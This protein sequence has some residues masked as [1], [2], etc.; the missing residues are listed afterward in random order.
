MHHLDAARMAVDHSVGRLDMGR[1]LA[2][3]AV[4][5]LAQM[6]RKLRLLLPAQMARPAMPV[7]Q[8][9]FIQAART[10]ALQPRPHRV[11]VEVEHL[12]HLDAA[13]AVIQEQN[14]VRAA[15]HPVGLAR[16]PHHR[17]QG[18]AFLDAQKST[19]NHDREKNRSAA[20]LPELFRVCGESGY[21]LTG[22]PTTANNR[23]PGLESGCLRCDDGHCRQAGRDARERNEFN[24]LP[25]DGR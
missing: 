6:G 14:G 20:R 13:R 18:R 10:V 3:I 8:R 16:M 25:R 21:I 4:K 22:M 2:G 17:L 7:E 9:H 5:P 15:R 23:G 19:A 12:R 1:H 24:T 11:V